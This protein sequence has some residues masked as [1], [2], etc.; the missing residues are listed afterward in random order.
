MHDPHHDDGADHVS[1]PHPEPRIEDCYDARPDPVLLTM[2]GV[3]SSL[4]LEAVMAIVCV[5]VD[6]AKKVRPELR[7]S[8]D[9]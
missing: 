6:L 3:S 8:V 5:G 7:S 1:E 4:V 2:G 9:A